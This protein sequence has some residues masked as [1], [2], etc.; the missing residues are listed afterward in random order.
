MNNI[1]IICL[2][3]ALATGC[4]TQMLHT[5]MVSGGDYGEFP[6]INL[7]PANQARPVIVHP[8]ARTHGKIAEQD[9]QSVV[10]LLSRLPKDAVPGDLEIVNVAAESMWQTVSVTMQ[11]GGNYM[12]VFVKVNNTDWKVAG[13]HHFVV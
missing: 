6:N 7:L 4:R 3:V 1:A 5:E 13:I 10:A 9:W 12:I 8:T 2:L 11:I